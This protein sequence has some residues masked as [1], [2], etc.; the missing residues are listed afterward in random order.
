M[1]RRRRPNPTIKG[2]GRSRPSRLGTSQARIHAPAGV[3]SMGEPLILSL[4]D[5]VAAGQAI[6]TGLWTTMSAVGWSRALASC[7]VPIAQCRNGWRRRVK[8]A[9]SSRRCAMAFGQPGH[10][11]TNRTW[12]S[13]RNGAGRTEQLPLS[14]IGTGPGS[15]LVPVRLHRP[16]LSVS[17]VAL[18]PLRCWS[19]A[20][21]W[22]GWA[23][24]PLRW[25]IGLGGLSAQFRQY[26]VGVGGPCSFGPLAEDS[27]G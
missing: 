14:R 24:P 2:S 17:S 4:V 15:G 16:G 21:W 12:A 23:V 11:T 22:V 3:P 1:R 7:T 20:G 6:S 18:S 19:A 13:D 8:A 5:L 9:P 10:A 27:V 25:V 26:R